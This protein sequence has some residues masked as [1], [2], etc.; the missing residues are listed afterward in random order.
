MTSTISPQ[1]FPQRTPRGRSRLDPGSCNLLLQGGGDLAVLAAGDINSEVFQVD[2]G[3]ALIS[4]GGSLGSARTVGDTNRSPSTE[5]VYTISVLG[6]A[7]KVDIRARKDATLDGAL[8]ATALPASVIN[9][10]RNTGALSSWLATLISP[11]FSIPTRR[12][13]NLRWPAL[14]AT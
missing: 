9:T 2:R 6:D 5:A 12:R 10:S 14:P 8:N 4:A 1:S 13:A 11:T 3:E 7:A